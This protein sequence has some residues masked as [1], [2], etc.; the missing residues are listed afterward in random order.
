MKR[1]L[2]FI[3]LIMGL[4][5]IGLSIFQGY[6]LYTS[7]GITKQQFRWDISEVLQ[8]TNYITALDEVLREKFFVK[9]SVVND[10]DFASK[11]SGMLLSI[12]AADYMKKAGTQ[13][14]DVSIR[15]ELTLPKDSSASGS[16][17]KKN[18]KAK[19]ISQP[20]DR[21]PIIKTNTVDDYYKGFIEYVKSKK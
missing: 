2:R 7:Y 5:L 3:I 12:R 15:I 19:D 17:L 9:D 20:K 8:R 21:W 1:K 14:K 13:K 11:F 18:K 16:K 6:W 4:S 10:H